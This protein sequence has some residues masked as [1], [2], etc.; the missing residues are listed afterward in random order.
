MFLFFLNV[1]ENMRIVG[2]WVIGV[3]ETVKPVPSVLF[4]ELGGGVGGQTLAYELNPLT[5]ERSQI[6]EWLETQSN[7][8][9]TVGERS[10]F[11]KYAPSITREGKQARICLT[12]ALAPG[13][14]CVIHH[15]L[16]STFHR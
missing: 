11:S 12:V 5:Y 10:G 4:L 13:N 9:A 16:T 2:V 6:Q 3:F 15:T 7:L 14:G 8:T 1:L